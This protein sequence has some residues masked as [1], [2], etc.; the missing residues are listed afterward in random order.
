[1]KQTLTVLLFLII[2][3]TS[4]AQVQKN[5][6]HGKILDSDKNILPGASVII[7]GTKYGVNA[8]EAGEYLFDQI[9]AGLI[10]VTG[11]VYRIQNFD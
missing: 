1:M 7:E 8:N 4:N 5:S 6:L 9:P 2:V 10:K 11:I 3:F